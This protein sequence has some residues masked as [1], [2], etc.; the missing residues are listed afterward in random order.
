M[1]RNLLGGVYA[2]TH[3]SLDEEDLLQKVNQILLSGIKIIQYRDKVRKKE[4]KLLIAKNLRSICNKFNALLIVNDDVGLAKEIEADGVHLGQEDMKY[5]EARSVLGSDL[6]IG[7]SCQ[8]NL[9]LALKAESEGA[10]YVAFGSLFQTKSKKDT[11][12]CSVDNLI[13][14]VQKL[15]VPIAAIGGINSTNISLVKD[16]GV[17][18]IAMS[19]GLFLEEDFSFLNL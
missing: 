15:N 18:M 10:D 9:E 2:V 19:S 13:S 12:K 6:I 16:S 1:K 7:I 17:D 11:V 14:Y 8:N 3:D 4:K 5:K